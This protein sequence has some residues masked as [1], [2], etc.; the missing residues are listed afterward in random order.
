MKYAI[1]MT[2]GG[3]IY[4]PRFLTIGP[5]IIVIFRLL[6]QQFGRLQYWI[7]DERDLRSTTL[8][9]SQVPQ[10]TNQVSN[11]SIQAFKSSYRGT[12]TDSKVIS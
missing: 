12:H 7:T 2:S 11:R 5:G 3:M 8:R 9:W 4:K 10:Y 6:P 1:E